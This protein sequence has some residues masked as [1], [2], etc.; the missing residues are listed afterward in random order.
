MGEVMVYWNV[1]RRIWSV[2]SGATG[3]VIAHC[4]SLWLENPIFYVS[5]AGRR[6]VIREGRKNVHA[7]V[8]GKL[9]APPPSRHLDN[10]ER[11]RYNPYETLTFE[12]MDGGQ[13]DKAAWASLEPDGKCYA[14]G[15]VECPVPQVEKKRKYEPNHPSGAN[16]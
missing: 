11:V 6:R 14:T 5:D 8:C 7:K 2:Q 9:C 15:I 16:R 3:R 1:R 10:Y 13:V 12:T 4:E